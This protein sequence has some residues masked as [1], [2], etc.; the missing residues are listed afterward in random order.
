MKVWLGYFHKKSLSCILARVL[1]SDR[2]GGSWGGREAIS[3]GRRVRANKFAE[4]AERERKEACRGIRT[5]RQKERRRKTVCFTGGDLWSWEVCVGPGQPLNDGVLWVTCR[6]RQTQSATHKLWLST[7]LPY[8]HKG[9]TVICQCLPLQG[10]AWQVR[11][12]IGWGSLQFW[13]EPP[14]L[15][16]ATWRS[17]VPFPHDTEH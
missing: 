13:A 17:W 14:E 8:F 9:I 1:L 7:S 11:V 15:E 10:G 3:R 16:H 12:V 5:I 6:E 2:K 4:T